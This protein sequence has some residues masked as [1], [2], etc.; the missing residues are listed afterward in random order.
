M[1]KLSM[2]KSALAAGNSGNR[3]EFDILTAIRN[4]ENAEVQLEKAR[5]NHEIAKSELEILK[6]AKISTQIK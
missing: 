5:L 4:V 1:N 3:T 2:L 6:I